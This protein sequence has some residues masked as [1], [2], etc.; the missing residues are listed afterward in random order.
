[1]QTKRIIMV[2][3]GNV[4]RSPMA[5]VLL[6]AALAEHGVDGVQVWSAGTWAMSDSPAVGQAA[7]VCQEEGLDLSQHR[8]RPL[9][10]DMVRQADMVLVMETRHL[11]EIVE[12]LPEAEGKVR[13]LGSFAKG[14]GRDV[15]EIKD[16][17]DSSY[18]SFRRCFNEIKEAVSGLAEYLRAD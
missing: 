17:F 9:A 16:P 7:Y 15:A 3:S 2:C 6:K 4:C 5:E 12:A 1:M 14:G 13:L 8:S 10:L 18:G 11:S